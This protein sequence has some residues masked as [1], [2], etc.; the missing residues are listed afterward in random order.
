MAKFCEW[1][2]GGGCCMG[3]FGFWVVQGIS[4]SAG[5]SGEGQELE[6]VGR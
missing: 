3:Y 2:E 4:F 5:Q 1:E 6:N